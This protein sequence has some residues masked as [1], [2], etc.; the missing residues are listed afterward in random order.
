M[1][2]IYAEWIGK[3]K[4]LKGTLSEGVCCD[5]TLGPPSREACE[6]LWITTFPSL[7]LPS[8]QQSTGGHGA[9]IPQNCCGDCRGNSE[10]LG[11]GSAKKT[12]VETAAS[13]LRNFNSNSPPP[14]P[15]PS[16]P[17]FPG[18]LHSNFG[19]F[20]GPVDGQLLDALTLLEHASH[21]P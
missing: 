16:T 17:S 20:R 19:E 4:A 18:S 7:D 15:P 8:P 14:P 21:R 6:N 5:W 1:P 13:L 3:D 12:A 11:L 9:R 10:C 2:K